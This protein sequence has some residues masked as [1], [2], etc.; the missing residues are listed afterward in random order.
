LGV[1]LDGETAGDEAGIAVAGAGD[2]DGDGFDD[3]LVGA[4]EES[5]GGAK[6]GAAYLLYGS[7]ERLP[8]S[9]SLSAAAARLTGEAAYDRAG[10]AVAAAGDVNGDGFGDVIVGAS[11]HNGPSTD[12]GAAYLLHGP[13]YGAIPLSLADA[14]L[15]PEPGYTYAGAAVAGTGDVDGDGFDDLAIGARGHDAH[16]VDAGAAW[17]VYGP[18]T[19]AVDLGLADAT[20]LGDAAGDL[21]GW[22]G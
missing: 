8:P 6:A 21:A 7:G 14:K 16:G 19:G 17:L 4:H 11:L 3:F 12:S 15:V 13:F 9:R 18:A 5:S 10:S 20:F 22:G 1:R 2:V